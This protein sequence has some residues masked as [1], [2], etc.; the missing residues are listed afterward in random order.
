MP[1]IER[2]ATFHPP[3]Y[4]AARPWTLPPDTEDVTVVTDDGVHLHGWFAKAAPAAPR[5]GVTVLFFH[6]N[7]QMLDT[8]TGTVALFQ[9]NGFDFF[10]VD[11]RGYGKSEGRSRDETTLRLDG[12]A[13]LR[14]LTQQRGLAPGSIAL[15]GQSLGTV[16]AADLAVSIPCR[17]LVLMAP[18]ASARQQAAAVYPYLPAFL[19][20]FM[21][22]PLDTVGKI[23]SARCP[24][25]VVHG[26]N[27]TVIDLAQGRA[28]YDAAR[29]PK[30][31][32]LVP[33]GG[34]VPSLTRGGAHV[35]DIL[36]FLA[37]P[38]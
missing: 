12:A 22:S 17:S 33:N 1:T 26:D 37:K 4:D 29:P 14:Y 38:E 5:T 11:Y 18:L 28:V 35:A 15:L 31:F 27:D 2:W 24:V 36:S 25:M 16:V 13:A 7:A 6:G 23:A 21:R 34:H 8:L 20:H 10:A 9:R 3:V 19:H 32:I 30:K